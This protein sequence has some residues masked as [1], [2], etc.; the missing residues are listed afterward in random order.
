MRPYIERAA[1][2]A[3]A[4]HI[5]AQVFL[6]QDNDDLE[7]LPLRPTPVHLSAWMSED[8]F[9][10]RQLRFVG[11]VGLS[12]LNARCAFDEPLESAI[13]ERIAQAFLEYVHTLIVP[14]FVDHI[15]QAE[16]MELQ[17]LYALPDLRS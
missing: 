15:A 2:V 10:A 3:I 11:V 16:V 9:T 14:K 13:V 7:F 6:S 12:G 17:K 4:S 1:D 5:A 8:D